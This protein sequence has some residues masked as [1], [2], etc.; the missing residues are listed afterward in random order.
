MTVPLI[1][2]AEARLLEAHLRSC[3]ASDPLPR[4]PVMLGE[5]MRRLRVAAA[6]QA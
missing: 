4:A 5:L 2:E 3:C 6:N 1:R